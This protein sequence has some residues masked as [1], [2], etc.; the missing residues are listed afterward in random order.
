LI[1]KIIKKYLSKYIMGNSLTWSP[2]FPPDK[3][4]KS[5]PFN[6]GK[7]ACQVKLG[8]GAFGNVYRAVKID[9]DSSQKYAV[10]IQK[11]RNQTQ[12]NIILQEINQHKNLDHPSIVKFYEAIQGLRIKEG[13]EQKVVCIVIELV[14]GATLEWI[15]QILRDQQKKLDIDL[16]AKWMY[17]LVTGVDYLHSLSKIHRDLKPANLLISSDTRDLKIADFGLAR[18]LDEEG[19]A[20]T[21]CGTPLYMAPEIQPGKRITLYGPEVDMWATGLILMELIADI[22]CNRELYNLSSKPSWE[23]DLMKKLTTSKIPQVFVEIIFNCLRLDPSKRL[24]SD[25]FVKNPIFRAYALACGFLDE[26]QAEIEIRELITTPQTLLAILLAIE[27]VMN[28]PSE[29]F[30]EIINWILEVLVANAILIPVDVMNHA[31]FPKL[32]KSLAQK[33]PLAQRLVSRIES[34]KRFS[35]RIHSGNLKVS[36]Y[37]NKIRKGWQ[38]RFLPLEGLHVPRSF[39]SIPRAIADTLEKIYLSSATD[40]SIIME[41]TAMNPDG[42]EDD[43]SGEKK[44]ICFNI[45]KMNAKDI[46]TEQNMELVR[47]PPIKISHVKIANPKIFQFLYGSQWLDYDERHQKILNL[48]YLLPEV[49]AI[50]LSI[51]DK[52]THAVNIKNFTHY[53]ISNLEIS[54]VRF[55]V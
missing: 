38:W 35:K 30:K 12:I 34:K 39:R 54:P 11:F 6:V 31:L 45:Q 40:F 44:L 42:S 20:S 7:Y 16:K 50:L 43:S 41:T 29:K 18:D 32:M 33:F 19:Q 13:I 53:S 52:H 46:S 5:I 10:K 25:N 55:V 9:P 2:I 37:P 8:K 51:N 22:P 15:F 4:A 47:E 14:E 48:A 1:F 36:S 21:I 49:T 3:P 26:D 28:T 17:Q 27:G 23:S 24:K